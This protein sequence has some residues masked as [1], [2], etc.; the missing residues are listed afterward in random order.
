[1]PEPAQR[2]PR[3]SERFP[4]WPD[5]IAERPA[6]QLV[7]ALVSTHVDEVRRLIDTNKRVAVVWRRGGGPTILRHL[8]ERPRDDASAVCR[9][10][11][12]SFSLRTL[13]ERLMKVFA[14]FGG[15]ALR[16]DVARWGDLVLAAPGSDLDTLDARLREIAP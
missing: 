4:G 8:I 5:E 13:L 15:E 16:G 6:F 1:M 9:S 14:R 7:A 12:T 10:R 2:A 11:S 3:R